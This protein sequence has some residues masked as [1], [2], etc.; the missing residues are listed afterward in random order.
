MNLD[1]L[2]IRNWVQQL[3]STLQNQKGKYDLTKESKFL[4]PIIKIH[5]L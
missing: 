2:G 3:Y 5:M 4:S 1:H